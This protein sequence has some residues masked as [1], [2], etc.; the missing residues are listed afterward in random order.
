MVHRSTNGGEPLVHWSPPASRLPPPLLALTRG[1]APLLHHYRVARLNDAQNTKGTVEAVSDIC[2][3]VLVDVPF[4][5]HTFL[6]P[7]L[8]TSIILQYPS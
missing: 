5:I 8:T 3:F 4:S 7:K 2:F 6:H 1:P